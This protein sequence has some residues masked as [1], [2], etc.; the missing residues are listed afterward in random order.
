MSSLSE[1]NTSRR[2]TRSTSRHGSEEAASVIGETSATPQR[3]SRRL[4]DRA[5]P[6]KETVQTGRK[7][8]NRGSAAYGAK[9]K[10]FSA[11]TLSREDAQKAPEDILSQ[12]VRNA[13]A[14]AFQT[15][16]RTRSLPPVAEESSSDEPSLLPPFEYLPNRDPN[17]DGHEG[18][19]PS[20]TEGNLAGPIDHSQIQVSLLERL[21]HRISGWFFG[22]VNTNEAAHNPLEMRTAPFVNDWGNYEFVVHERDTPPAARRFLAVGRGA[23]TL[24]LYFAFAAM[25]VLMGIV[26]VPAITRV[27]IFPKGTVIDG[28]EHLGPRLASLEAFVTHLVSTNS[29]VTHA[30]YQID[31]FAKDNDAVVDPYLTSPSHPRT[32]KKI[33]WEDLWWFEKFI[34]GG[35]TRCATD[36]PA[37]ALKSWSD[38]GDAFCAPPR[39]GKLQLTVITPRSISPTELIVENFPREALI[40]KG[41]TPKE[42]ELWVEVP[43]PELHESMKATISKT[44]AHLLTESAPQEAR[45]LASAQVLPH[46]YLPIGRWQYKLW[47]K[48]NIQAFKIPLDLKSLD[49]KANKFAFRVNSNW[50]DYGLTCLY[51]IRL[52]GHDMSD[53]PQESLEEE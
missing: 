3:S 22:L 40:I 29:P 38:P 44:Q 15:S 50:G 45:G 53:T 9:G 19:Q 43:D 23:F 33:P 14:T 21:G 13:E 35:V 8:G 5:T 1:Q 31:W 30:L 4:R 51:R 11:S 25:I 36:A 41:N 18:A 16:G 6:A 12:A 7:I 10:N 37:Q 27:T 52:F 17:L 48:N 20:A 39:R 2:V 34:S 49:L 26:V 28:Y 32:C 46:T 24:F 42:I 47:G